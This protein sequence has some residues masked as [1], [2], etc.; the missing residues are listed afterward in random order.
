MPED[1]SHTEQGQVA[2]AKRLRER[3]ESLRQGHAPPGDPKTPKSL[4]E[5]LDERA[6]ERQ[7]KQNRL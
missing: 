7:E 2:R 6:R 5:Q 4:K 3:I 1:Q